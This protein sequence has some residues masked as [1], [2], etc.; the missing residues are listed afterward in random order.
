[1]LWHKQ[2]PLLF[3]PYNLR[4]K[5]QQPWQP[6]LLWHQEEEKTRQCGT[7]HLVMG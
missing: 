2:L 3:L 6:R 5:Q 4:L 7:S 1:M